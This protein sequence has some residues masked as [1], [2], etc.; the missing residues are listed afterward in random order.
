MTIRSLRKSWLVAGMLCT[1][2][3]GCSD[4][5]TVR[6]WSLPDGNE[7]GRPLRFRQD[8]SSLRLS[9][10]GRRLFIALVD[11]DTAHTTIQVWDTSVPAWWPPSSPRNP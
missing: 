6:I 4:D 10:D 1:L 3:M 2:G 7:L 8:V 9:P 11:A 5:N